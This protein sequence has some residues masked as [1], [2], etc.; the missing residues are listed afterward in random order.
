MFCFLGLLKVFYGKPCAKYLYFVD[1][2]GYE[3]SS[4]NIPTHSSRF[5]MDVTPSH[6]RLVPLRT[7]S[8]HYSSLFS[9]WVRYST[10]L[11]FLDFLAYHLHHPSCIVLH[12]IEHSMFLFLDLF[13]SRTVGTVSHSRW[14]F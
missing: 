3:F 9:H 10:F 11:C 2:D 12:N 7:L 13:I 8:L 6:P 4:L 5:S 14:S 1:T